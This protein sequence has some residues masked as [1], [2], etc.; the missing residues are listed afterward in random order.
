MNIKTIKNKLHPNLYSA[1]KEF[2]ELRPAQ[3]KS[4]KA[5]L[6]DKNNLLVCTPTAS[7][8]TLIAE[9]A[10][11]QNIYNNIGKSIY[12]VPLKALATEKYNYF[13]SKYNDIKVG[14]YIEA[15]ELV[16][17]KRTLQI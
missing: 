8:K 1:L 12:I 11:L 6:L 5:G 14:D 15:Y 13:K 9:I 7:G 17:E 10:M 4:I 3:A 2:N 16:Q